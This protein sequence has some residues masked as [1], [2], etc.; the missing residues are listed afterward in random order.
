MIVSGH[1][2]KLGDINYIFCSDEYL[3]KVNIDY[4]QHNYYT[5]IITFPYSYDPLDADIYISVDRL[6]ENASELDIPFLDE[7]HR[8]MA[9]G[10]LHMCGFLDKLP[11][12]Q[13]I[14]SLEENKALEIWYELSATK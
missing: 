2:K 3:L 1:G 11:E 12:E 10:I 4:L 6:R 5:D 7:L 13:R 9:H 14:M 8:V